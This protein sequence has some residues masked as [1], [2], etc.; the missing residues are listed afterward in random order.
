MVSCVPQGSVL[1]PLLFI[2]YTADIWND[3]ENKMISYADDSILYAEFASLSNR[4]N[5]ANSLKKDLAKIQSW[6]SM[7]GMKLNP[8]KT[9]SV[10]IGHSKTP[11]SLLI[12]CGLDLEVSSSLKLLGVT[13]KS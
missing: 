7:W 13:I 3:L 11:H 2:L 1:G 5:V 8:F 10:T 12:G 6:C 4:M 9:H